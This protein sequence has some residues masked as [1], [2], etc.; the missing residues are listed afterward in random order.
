MTGLL[1]FTI[2]GS[3][4]S[5]GVPRADGNWGDCDPAEPRNHRS[6]CS[7]LVRRLGEGGPRHQT[8]VVVDTSPDLRLQTAQAGVQRVDA[9][10]Y[11]HDHADQAHGIDDLRPFFLNQRERIPTYMDQA[12]WDGLLNRF[13]YVF[14]TRGGYPAILDPRLIPPLGVD[15]AIEGPSGAIPVHTFDVDHGGVRAVGYRFGGVAYTPDVRAIPD[16]SWADLE[17]LDV[18]IVDALRWTPHPTHAHVDLALEWIAKAKPRRAI[19]TNLHIDLDYHVLSARL[20]SGVEA[21][22][23][24]M[25]FIL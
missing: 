7:L 3:G 10:L 9:A 21:A 6:R 15:F 18:W 4:S 11:T 12:T 5:G 24:G 25:R 2:L 16:G 23:D 19:L 20:P 22:Y 14:E 13:S 8:T 17:D 1:E